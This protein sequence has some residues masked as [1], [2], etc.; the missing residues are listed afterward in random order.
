M[1][2]IRDPAAYLIPIAIVVKAKLRHGPF[3]DGEGWA[4]VA[5]WLDLLMRVSWE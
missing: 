3:F 2:D 1:I 5:A 4:F